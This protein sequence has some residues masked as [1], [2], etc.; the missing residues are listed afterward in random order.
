[1]YLKSCSISG[2]MFTCLDC[3]HM[4]DSIGCKS[5]LNQCKGKIVYQRLDDALV[6]LVL[7]VYVKR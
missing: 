1:M 6:D 7:G 3:K 5:F 2:L 4:F